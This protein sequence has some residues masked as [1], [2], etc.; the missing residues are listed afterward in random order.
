MDFRSLMWNSDE[1]RPRALIRLL[2]GFFVIAT[3]AVIG[4]IVMDLIAV[5][6]VQPLSFG[7]Q[8]LPHSDSVS[9]PSL[10]S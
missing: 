6:F 2:V 5:A 4:T 8:S 10:V 1:R 7:Y 3:F 9:G